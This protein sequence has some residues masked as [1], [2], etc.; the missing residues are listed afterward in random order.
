MRYKKESEVRERREEEIKFEKEIFHT[1]L[2]VSKTLRETH[3]LT[4][5]TWDRPWPNQY[6]SCTTNIYK[7]DAYAGARRFDPE[8]RQYASR[9]LLR[10]DG[11][12]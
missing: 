10:I 5:P 9:V 2:A 11:G 7:L 6:S 3:K 8:L 12:L 4:F 1:W